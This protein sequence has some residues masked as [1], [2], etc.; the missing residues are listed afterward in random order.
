[1]NHLE[2]KIGY[3]LSARVKQQCESL[4]I[5]V[6]VTDRVY[7]SAFYFHSKKYEYF[8]LEH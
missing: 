5:S 2:F 3:Y 8:S 7:N 4:N 6:E 1:M